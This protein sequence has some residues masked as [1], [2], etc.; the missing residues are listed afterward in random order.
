MMNRISAEDFWIAFSEEFHKKYYL[1]K[2]ASN[3]AY[4]S[5]DPWTAWMNDF[6]MQ[7]G[8]QLNYHVEYEYFDRCDYAYFS[9]SGVENWGKWSWEVAIE[10]ENDG[11]PKLHEELHKLMLINAG[12]KVLISYRKRTN[13]PEFLASDFAEFKE[14]YKSRKYH[15]EDD[16]YLFI[17][18]PE[19]SLW[20]KED[21]LAFS[22]DGKEVINITKN[23]NTF[24]E[25]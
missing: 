12:L 5:D 2:K 16:N 10:H 1:N 7:L 23:K 8:K 14:I 18:G 24:L 11:W 6:I 17:Y 25:K 3:E 20:E 19:L 22:F 15:Q 4:G 13:T 9:D 21:F